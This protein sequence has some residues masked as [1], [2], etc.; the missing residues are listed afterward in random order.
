MK[1]IASLFV[2]A[3]LFSFGLVS[4]ASATA[5]PP[6]WVCAYKT[7][8]VERF[9]KHW[10][11][12]SVAGQWYSVWNGQPTI[13]ATRTNVQGANNKSPTEYAVNGFDNRDFHFGPIVSVIYEC[14]L[15]DGDA[16]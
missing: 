9:T 7:S 12:Q 16:K 15:G 1:Y 5:G 14:L 8:P 6:A 13:Q 3:L 11:V 10:A 4:N 2:V